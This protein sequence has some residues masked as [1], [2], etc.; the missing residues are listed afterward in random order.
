MTNFTNLAGALAARYQGMLNSGAI[1]VKSD[2]TGIFIDRWD[3]A[4]VGAP[5]PAPAILEQWIAEWEAAELSQQLAAAKAA[6]L[7]ALEDG[8][9]QA[10]LVITNEPS[11]DALKI[12]EWTMKEA[13]W[14]AWQVAGQPAPATDNDYAWVLGEAEQYIADP[15]SGISTASDLIAEWGVN[16]TAWRQLQTGVIPAFRKA[17]KNAIAAAADTEPLGEMTADYFKAALLAVVE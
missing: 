10:A 9:Y 14:Q 17:Q 3:E 15:A 6:A 11:L 4:A 8:I 12:A 1:V 2:H 7:A 16:A 13:T 5:E